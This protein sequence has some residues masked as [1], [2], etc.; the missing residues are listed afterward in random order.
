MQGGQPLDY[1]GERLP[2]ELGI[3]RPDA[4][5]DG[6]VGIQTSVPVHAA[7]MANMRFTTTSDLSSFNLRSCQ[8]PRNRF[9]SAK[10]ISMRERRKLARTHVQRCARLLTED[11]LLVDCVVLDLTND[12]A[13]IRVQ[14]VSTVS[15]VISLTFDSGRSNR[16]CRLVWLGADRMGVQFH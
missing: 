5:A 14:D 13:G 16:S 1:V 15:R 10:E 7:L 6:A 11:S 9:G 12:G 2:I 8:F 3:L 4:V